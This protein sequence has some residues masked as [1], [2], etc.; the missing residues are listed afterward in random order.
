MTRD[1]EWGVK[2][3]AELGEKW[4]NKVMYVW[5]SSRSP[6]IAF[7]RIPSD[8]LSSHLVQFDAPIGYPSI[9]A[10]YTDDWKMWWRNPE[11]VTLYQFMGKVSW[12]LLAV[13]LITILT[14]STS[15]G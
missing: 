9:T 3:P 12:T 8:L 14:T 6:H 5:V 13:Y 1:L 7:E 11:N 15:A 10:N 4:E 2:L